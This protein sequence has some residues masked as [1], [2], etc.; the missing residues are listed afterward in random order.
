MNESI[1]NCTIS[2]GFMVS[3][4]FASRLSC[5]FSLARFSLWSW[6]HL[7]ELL[8][9]HRVARV[10]QAHKKHKQS[11][12]VK[13]TV[14][15]EDLWNGFPVYAA[16]SSSHSRRLCVMVFTIYKLEVFRQT[17]GMQ[18]HKEKNKVNIYMQLVPRSITIIT[19]LSSITR[20]LFHPLF[21]ITKARLETT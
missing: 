11:A 6:F 2:S 20:F 16:S 15:D 13:T 19:E 1:V 14:C 10:T 8:S 3:M 12:Q 5:I 17:I 4:H 7:L 21:F 9:W 18:Q